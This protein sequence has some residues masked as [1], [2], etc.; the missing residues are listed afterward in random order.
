MTSK[1]KSPPA[2][3]VF[4]GFDDKGQHVWSPFVVKLETRLRFGNLSYRAE[5]GSLFKAPRGKIPY[6]SIEHADGRAET[7]GDSTLITKAFIESG[8]LEDLNTHLSAIEQL[9]DMAIRALL[10]EKLYFYQGHE[11]WILNYYAMQSKIFGSLPWPIRTILGNIVYNKTTKAMEGQGTLKFSAEEI[12]GFR[13]DI[14]QAMNNYVVA[15]MAKQNDRDGP[16][17]LLGGDQPTEGD[18]VLFSFIASN[19]VS[20]A[21]PDSRQT[22]KSHPPLMDYARRIHEKYFPDYELWES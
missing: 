2:I 18:A 10:E 22:L 11:R 13:H 9:Q 4:R 12:L 15:I 14:W 3:T 5:A 6:I 1:I 21:A 20:K 7:L 19:L 16:V 8:Y 17:W